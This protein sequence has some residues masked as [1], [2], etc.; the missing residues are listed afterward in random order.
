MSS[1][2]SILRALPPGA[3]GSCSLTLF[4]AGGPVPGATPAMWAMAGLILAIVVGSTILLL[5]IRDAL[6]DN[7]S[8]LHAIGGLVLWLGLALCIEGCRILALALATQEGTQ[9]RIRQDAWIGIGWRTIL[10]AA[11]PVFALLLFALGKTFSRNRQER[12]EG[13]RA[14]HLR[15]TLRRK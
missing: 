10:Y 8:W 1:W 6:E 4:G 14:R 5:V 9:P 7:A 13:E 11:I 3:E 12:K 2:D 15:G